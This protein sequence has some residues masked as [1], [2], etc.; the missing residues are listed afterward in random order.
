M[1]L[2]CTAALNAFCNPL[3]SIGAGCARLHPAHSLPGKIHRGSRWCDQERRSNS[4][5]G[6]GSGT[7]RSLF[8]LP[9]PVHALS[10]ARCRCPLLAD[11]SLPTAAS[12]TSRSDSNRLCSA[13][14][15]PPPRSAGLPRY[16]APRAVSFRSAAAPPHTPPTSASAPPRTE[17]SPHSAP[18]SHCY[19]ITPAHSSD[20]QR[21]A[22]P[23]PH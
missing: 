4:K 9:P 6:S 19:A 1:P 10:S 11:A 8:P 2:A 23:P 5:V 22:A 21:T 3:S 13:V 14:G 20:T 18:L 15:A 12:H 7:S 16:S 17:T